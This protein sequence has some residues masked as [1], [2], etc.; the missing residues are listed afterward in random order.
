M[1]H[2]LCYMY[3]SV[4]HVKKKKKKKKKKKRNAEKMLSP[5]TRTRIDLQTKIREANDSITRLERLKKVSLKKLEDLTKEVEGISAR[6]LNKQE[7]LKG[8]NNQLIQA[9][10]NEKLAKKGKERDKKG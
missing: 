3:E 1:G 5:E 4:C 8:L 6:L 7:E 10:A 2:Q 9:K